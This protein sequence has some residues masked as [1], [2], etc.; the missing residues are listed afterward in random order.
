VVSLALGLAMGT[1]SM[2]VWPVILYV[3]A[4]RIQ[5]D[6]RQMAIASK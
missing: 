5:R 3:W 6:A 2:S 4:G 1:V